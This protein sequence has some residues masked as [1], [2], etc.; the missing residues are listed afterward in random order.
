MLLYHGS[1][2]G[3]IRILKPRLADHER[4][5]IYMST[6][7]IVAAF[8][9]V[10]AVERPYY[11]FPYGFNKAGDVVYEELYPHALEEV[12]S[13]KKGYIYT[14]NAEE[15]DILPFKNIPCARLA[16]TPMKALCCE[17]ITD[18]YKW[19]LQQENSGKFIIARFE[20]KTE[21]QMIRWRNNIFE[22]IKEKDMIHTPD[23]SYAK[24]V[25][26]KFPDVWERYEREN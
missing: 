15:K 7:E 17:E 25:R 26:S 2:T 21:R 9:M 12:S 6:I 22:Y 18:C 23:C 13:G 14:V 20:E 3:S 1:G 10:N 16:T 5:Y 4:P 24:F 11:W 19:F 8:Y